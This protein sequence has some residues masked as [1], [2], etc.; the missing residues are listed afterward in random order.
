MR[1]LLRLPPALLRLGIFLAAAA[2]SSQDF[3]W[4]EPERL[5]G[6][7]ATFLQA[8]SG[9]G[10]LVAA[11]QESRSSAGG[12]KEAWVSLA[13]ASLDPRGRPVWVKRPWAVGPIVYSGSEPALFSLCL[14][15]AGEILVA[16]PRAAGGVSVWISRDGGRSFVE[17]ILD[18]QGAISPRV[19]RLSAGGYL[20][21]ASRGESSSF[22]L[23]RSRSEDGQ[24]WTPAEPL[25]TEQNLKIS[26]LPSLAGSGGRDVL[27][28]QSR[29][30]AE[31]NTFQLY[32]KASADGGRS[33]SQAFRLTNA[34]EQ[35]PGSKP[36]Y[37]DNQNPH[38]SLL[39]PA[40]LALVWEGGPASSPAQAY[41]MPLDLSGRPVGDA[42]RVS[43]GSFTC[44][45]PQGFTVAGRAGIIW[46][47]N[48]AAGSR[49]LASLRGPLGWEP[50][51][52]GGISGAPAFVRP[53]AAEG[54]LFIVW[55]DSIE[56]P[57]GILALAPDRSVRPPTLQAGNFD[58]GKPNRQD[59]VLLRWSPPRDS[60]GIA[61]YSAL[62]SRDPSAL[63]P[64]T[65]GLAASA[66]S[67]VYSADQDG[68]WFFKLRALDYAG[69]WSEAAGIE[70]IR[71][72]TPPPAPIL[73]LPQLD[74]SGSLAS[75][76]FSLRWSMPDDSGLAGFT[77]ALSPLAS[78]PAPA[79]D[80]EPLY[81]GRVLG[82][83]PVASYENIDNGTWLFE[84][85]AI[86]EVGNISAPARAV[87][88]ADKFIPYTA[89]AFAEA[90]Q[91]ESG[92]L[93]LS[94]RGRGFT[95]DGL[96]QRVFIDA[97]GRE[98]W[99][100]EFL[101]SR[102]DFAIVSDRLIRGI[103]TD[104]LE[105]G[106]YRVGVDH[107]SRG[108]LFTQP[109]LSVLAGGTVKYGDYR[110]SSGG[111]W[112]AV[113]E[114]RRA[115]SP[116][117]LPVA[118]LLALCAA[119]ALVAGRRL[120]GAVQDGRALDL[121]IKA[122]FQG[123]LM[124]AMEKTR[125][126]ARLRRRGMGL[127]IKFSI[128][129]I[130]LVVPIVMMV[131]VPLGLYSV[132]RQS[133]TLRDG[134]E[135]RAKVL[136]GSLA[137]SAST[138]MGST[139]ELGQALYQMGAMEEA[140]YITI[141]GPAPGS[142][143]GDD[144]VWA[145]NDAALETSEGALAKLGSQKLERG[146]SV[147]RDALTDSIPAIREKA[148]EAAATPQ[149]A[150][151]LD[152]VKA[153][154]AEYRALSAK[155]RKTPE[156]QAR[157]NELLSL[158]EAYNRELGQ[159]LSAAS[160]SLVGSIPDF[161][162]AKLTGGDERFLFYKPV[163]RYDQNRSDYYI[164]MVRLEVSAASINRE[165]A[166]SRDTIL[167]I[168]AAIALVAIAIG[169]LGA[170]VLALIIIR[171]IRSLVRGVEIIRDTPSKDKLA[172][173]RIDVRS[174]DELRTLSDTINQ[175]TVGLVRGAKDNADLL[176]GEQDQR[177]LLPLLADQA[178]RKL[179]IGSMDDGAVEF[180][181]YYKGAKLVS[182]DYLDFRP[183]GGGY[184]AFIKCDVSG[185]GVSAAMIMAVVASVFR[186]WFIGWTESKPG[187]AV[188]RLCYEI[189][190]TLNACEFRGKFA[191]LMIGILDASTGQVRLCHAGD[192]F[193][194]IFDAASGKLITHEM[195]GSAP[196]GPFDSEMI[197]SQTPFRIESRLIHP[198]DVLLLYTDGIDEARRYIRDAACARRPK[199]QSVD[200]P[201]RPRRPGGEPEETDFLYE[202]F[203]NERA[204]AIVEAVMAGRRYRLERSEDPESAA[205]L[206]F[207]FSD[208]RGRLEDM[209]LALV[210]VE[211]VFRLYR[212]PAAGEDDQVKTDAR[213]DDFLRRHFL[214]YYDF[215][216]DKRD[217]PEERPTRPPV[218]GGSKTGRRGGQDGENRAGMP[219]PTDA[220]QDAQVEAPPHYVMYA[221]LKEDEQYDDITVLA[222][223]RK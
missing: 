43:Q 185:K 82:T 98:P 54:L 73:E 184:Y 79:E 187:F 163:L 70:F 77:W 46:S 201:A 193:Y 49:A 196:A 39:D 137:S 86:D 202:D 90:E 100:R 29:V 134:L 115:L 151:R 140:V 159:L 37:W 208:C 45:N 55:Q 188:D 78:G 168:A 31:A 99:D 59:G 119:L 199:P 24:A 162:T 68:V 139:L 197:R 143:S 26:F 11:W 205:G 65:I 182:G 219:A 91:D 211:K 160:D 128:F 146:V 141:S 129:M 117:A 174:H 66:T 16:C 198:G 186:R 104:G 124:P 180:F 87:L 111:G 126:L 156:D 150:S 61:G 221:H 75:N 108:I 216:A 85:A 17:S 34:P 42:E 15:P 64:E 210:S 28:F 147:L 20:L 96:V 222:I 18:I 171:P 80:A 81:P 53:L 133:A 120:A 2:L 97:D 94:I 130:A 3:Y 14:G 47:D 167:G 121:E 118:A 131:S 135:R 89:I 48:R 62:W 181:G 155:P 5:A 175:M 203:G 169:V 44:S 30:I 218:Q 40:N 127:R 21:V 192:K 38:L 103:S 105:A 177:E 88:R 173:L 56:D 10:V 158:T 178:R 138:Y 57:K 214:R 23:L 165:I 209:V 152:T 84:V 207:D 172:G 93:K 145:T 19:F 125:K 212:D 220:A 4:D 153:A 52:L 144:I 189:N 7:G 69:N 200:A 164:G 106:R 27:V 149:F 33:W 223:R 12:Q 109:V 157:I 148:A 32:S 176:A 166:A 213:I 74:A 132:L 194:R 41:W 195:E 25:I 22:T 136:L 123:G 95:A 58:S 13:Q 35:T 60:S 110:P 63:P 122:L 183:L 112:M 204:A 217:N 161:T 206:E 170:L 154:V 101:R 36:S 71:D 92:L 83:T 9:Q 113:N 142:P 6:A 1:C 191:T 114:A 72:T 76:S 51:E 102:G 107:A 215:C 50:I 8:Q 116:Y 190:D 67:A 179:S